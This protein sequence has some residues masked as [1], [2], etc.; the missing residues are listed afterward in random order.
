[1]VSE[2]KRELRAT[3]IRIKGVT[4]LEKKVIVTYNYY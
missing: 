3:Q 2:K 4:S 1:M